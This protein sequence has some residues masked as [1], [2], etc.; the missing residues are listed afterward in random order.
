MTNKML[1]PIKKFGKNC[2]IFLYK[3]MNR[4]FPIQKNVIVFNCSMG[5]N[6]TGNCRYIYENMVEQGL[7]KQYKCVWFFRDT[8]VEIPGE[9]VIVP[10]ARLQYLY[11][12]A[13]A[14]TW[15]FDCRQ[16]GF[17]KKKEKVNYIQTWHGT[18]LKKLALDMDGVFMVNS[19]DITAYKEDFRNNANSWDYLISQNPFST[20]VFRRCFDFKKTMLEF[21]YPRNDSL[22]CD[23]NEKSINA[24]KN[25]WGLPLNKKIILYA[26]TWRDDEY[27]K[28]GHY[29]FRP[30]LD[31]DLLMEN[32]RDEFVMIV[33]YH[34][35]IQDGI[36]WT[37]YKGFIY[38]FDDDITGMYLVSDLMITDYSSVMFDYSV[39]K[40]P[41]FFYCYDLDKYKDELRGF[42]FDLQIEAPG[43]ISQTTSEVIRDIKE[44]NVE[45]YK[46]RYAKFIEKYNP[47]DDGN[48]SK[49][50]VELIKSF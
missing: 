1:K 34:Y 21:G 43:P 13:V 48:A 31:F 23:N 40:R 19:T 47:W 12:M 38:H 11:Y 33:K 9:A 10:Y 24:L 16:P 28:K 25:R 15:V 32:L 5:R 17:L 37:P 4:T 14:K 26:P 39:L 44:Y 30:K 8:N 42:Y 36:D 29:K 6:Y 35:L 41:M 2:A 3:I 22:I 20:T 7:D 50:V 46:E 18:P 49:K 45:E 27:D